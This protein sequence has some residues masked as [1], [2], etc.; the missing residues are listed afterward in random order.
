LDEIEIGVGAGAR[1][2]EMKSCPAEAA[3]G[4]TSRRSTR[5]A[6]NLQGGS[7]T[8][9]WKELHSWAQ[10][11]LPRAGMTE[12]RRNEV[13]MIILLLPTILHPGDMG[14]E[15]VEPAT[16]L[17]RVSESTAWSKVEGPVHFFQERVI[18]F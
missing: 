17:R 2:G 15:D 3:V 14:V 6:E 9:S 10:L 11:G 1:V 13:E 12:D 7:L 5:R 4:V 8:N 16:S 18:R